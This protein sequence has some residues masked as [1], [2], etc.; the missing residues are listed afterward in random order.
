MAGISSRTL[1][2]S[3]SRQVEECVPASKDG[4]VGAANMLP[5]FTMDSRDQSPFDEQVVTHGLGWHRFKFLG[6]RP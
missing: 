1:D 5:P 4:E 3:G 2:D 6:Y